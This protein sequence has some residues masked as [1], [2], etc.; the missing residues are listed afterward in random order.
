MPTEDGYPT[1][2]ELRTIRDWKFSKAHS[3]GDW[4][5]YVRGVW[6]YPE[7]AVRVGDGWWYFSTGGWSGNEELIDSMKRN[8]VGWMSSWEIHRS[9][10]HWWFT[11]RVRDPLSWR[12]CPQCEG[13]G[14][15]EEE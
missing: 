6:R 7:R 2:E 8:V 5:E 1:D 10:G 13:R 12:V 9:G 3:T 15:V 4:L 11:D 14:M